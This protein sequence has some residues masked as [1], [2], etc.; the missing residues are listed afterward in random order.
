MMDESRSF[1]KVDNR[2][3]VKIGDLEEESV[4][5]HMVGPEFSEEC[6]KQQSVKGRKC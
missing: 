3:A 4:V 1:N 5:L 6:R 2:E